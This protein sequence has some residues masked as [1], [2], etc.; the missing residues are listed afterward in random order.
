MASVAVIVVLCATISGIVGIVSLL[1]N[2]GSDP[3]NEETI[4]YVGMVESHIE[5]KTLTH[6]V[7]MTLTF[8][9]ALVA[10]SYINDADD[11]GQLKG[12]V[13][14]NSLDLDFL[15]AV[16]PGDC[17][18][19]GTLSDDRSTISAIYQCV[20]GEYATVNVKKREPAE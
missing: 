8:S 2:G 19:K 9:G 3:A 13:T 18:M 12:T 15:S 6:K 5:D 17:T 7:E 4:K 10:G 16:T 14:G 1:P 20:D 11:H